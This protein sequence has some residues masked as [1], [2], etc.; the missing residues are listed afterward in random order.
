MMDLGPPQDKG[1]PDVPGGLPAG[2]KDGNGVNILP[3]EKDQGR[4]K[5]GPEGGQLCG[6]EKR[7]RR[8]GR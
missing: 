2:A 5:S 7:I 8:S 4:R 6:S 3:T 1:E